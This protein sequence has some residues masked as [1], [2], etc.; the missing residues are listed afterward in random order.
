MVWFW[1]GFDTVRPG[2]WRLYL[3]PSRN[4]PKSYQEFL[5]GLIRSFWYGMVW[6]S[7]DMIGPWRGRLSQPISKPY[8]IV[9]RISCCPHKQF[10]IWHDVAWY[11]FAMVGPG[12]RRLHHNPYQN[13]TAS[14][15][16]FRVGL[17][18]S[19]WYYG[20]DTDVMWF[21]YGRAGVALTTSQPISEH[22]TAYQGVRVALT[23]SFWYDALCFS[24]GFDMVLVR[25]GID[26]S[27]MVFIWSGRGGVDYIKTHVGTISH[28]IQDFLLP[29]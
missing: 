29:A 6:Y 27:G 4:H 16:E 20:F 5:A 25:S 13:H 12:R 26:G 19:F 22:T 28:R 18:G 21:W 15:Q 11:G 24:C 1:Y 17:I 7:F 23:R 14:Y 8:Y 3:N 2:R 10:M 9:S